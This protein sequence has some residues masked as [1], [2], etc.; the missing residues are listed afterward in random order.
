MAHSDP[1]QR[2]NFHHLMYFWA[3]AEEGTLLAASKRLHVTHSTLSKQ[4]RDLET[5]LGSP[6][7]ERKGRRLALTPFGREVREYATDVA[8]LGRELVEFADGRHGRRRGRLRVGVV[9]SMPK[10]LVQLLLA[11]ALDHEEAQRAT[12]RQLSRAELIEWVLAGRLDVAL[13]DET[14]SGST[15]DT[16]LHAHLLGETA[17]L[18]YA[19]RRTAGAIARGFPQSLAEVGV[20]L[21]LAPSPLRKQLDQWLLREGLSLN[22]VIETDDAGLLRAFGA[23]GRGVLPVR[24]ALRSEVEDLHAMAL[25]GE[26]RGVRERYFALTLERKIRHPA[27][28]AM[29]EHAREAL[30]PVRVSRG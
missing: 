12:V 22:P 23:A 25:V 13:V 28:V 27:I 29:L 9:S 19:S 20:L 17:V 21:P 16:R 11:P 2:L 14:P 24:A 30:V 15:Q 10:T 6:I 1:L 8:R 3:V 26:C 5:A 4:L 7:F 18:W